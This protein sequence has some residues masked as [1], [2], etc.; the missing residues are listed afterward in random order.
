M[1]VKKEILKLL[2]NNMPKY[3]L[4]KRIRYCILLF[5]FHVIEADSNKINLQ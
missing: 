3:T 5:L 4:A 1:P 2:Q